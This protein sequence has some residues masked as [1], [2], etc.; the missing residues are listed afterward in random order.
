MPDAI[1]ELTTAV[2]DL[3]KIVKGLKDTSGSRATGG[4]AIRKAGGR[5]VRETPWVTTGQVGRDSQPFSITR[6]M[7]NGIANQNPER[8]KFEMDVAR[9]FKKALEKSV[10]TSNADM[11]MGSNTFYL[12]FLGWHM[13]GQ[14]ALET[15]DA[16]YCKAVM[17]VAQDY[18]P[19]EAQWFINRNPV[20]RK[21]QSAFEEGF[22]GTLVAPPLQGAAIPIIR[23]KAAFLAAGAQ[24]VTLPPQGKMVRPRLVQPTIASALGE[25]NLTVDS[26]VGT[27][28]MVMMA[29][30][31]GG[32]TIITEEANTF[33][34]GTID[35]L[36]RAD[37]DRTLG[38]KLDAY[39]FYGTGG[40]LIPSGITAPIYANAIINVETTYAAGFRGQGAN[41]NTL[42]PQYGD[43][44]PALIGERSFDV[45]AATGAFVMRPGALAAARAYRADA[46]TAGD[47][48]G[49]FVDVLRKF[50]DRG[51]E[52]WTGKKIVQTTNIYGN[53]VKGTNTNLSDVFYGIWEH[54]I[55]AAYGAIQFTQGTSGT[56]F[57]QGQ[58]RI[59]GLLYGDIGFEYPEAF[60]WYPHVLGI[61]GQI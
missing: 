54:A 28:Q 42:L 33:T 50:S 14:E 10:G 24:T 52:V 6:F 2:T 8:G 59:R 27:G 17:S 37:L 45:E 19:E 51:P 25:G 9:R 35:T 20:Y 39:A 5:E 31:I 16:K 36:V 29:K 46:V 41:G 48:A 4:D 15:E 56:D 12:P 13:L 47:Q 60:L 23:P 7:V 18:D 21:A 3:T 22:G 40:N 57:L 26:T 61:Q 30:K 1:A 43:F 34:S 53:T 55:L 58:Y 49:V 11:H 32:S 44:F 38:L